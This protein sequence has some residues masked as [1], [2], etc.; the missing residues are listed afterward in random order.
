[1]NPL[2]HDLNSDT[3]PPPPPKGERPLIP[4]GEA[5]GRFLAGPRPRIP[6]FLEIMRI[7]REFLRG[8]RKLHF[9][10]PC[11]TVFGSARFGAEHPHYALARE[12][13]GQLARGGFTVMTGGGPGIMEAANRGAREAGGRSIGAAIVLPHEEKPNPYL[14]SWV[15]FEYFFVRKVMLIKYSYG[16]VVLPGGFGTMD[17]IFETL[18]LIQTRKIGDFPIVVMGSDYWQP[19]LDFMR[20]TMVP[21]GTISPGDPDLLMV[22]DS[23]E[24]AVLHIRRHALERSGLRWQ[25]L[26]KPWLGE[27]GP[28]SWSRRR[29][30]A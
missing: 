26:P 12:L 25:P 18:T 23:P 17:E 4:S 20:Q 7:T 28:A 1:M 13:G 24:E 22:T 30:G 10:G 3:S 5:E 16:F 9:V 15:A 2:Q 29:G 14:D 6:E 11:V 8:F 19:I 27:Q 21:A